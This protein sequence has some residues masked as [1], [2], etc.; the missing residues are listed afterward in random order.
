MIDSNGGFA[1]FIKNY[2]AG[3]KEKFE[4]GDR[5]TFYELYD[6]LEKDIK[7]EK[8]EKIIKGL[9]INWE[10]SKEPMHLLLRRQIL[11]IRKTTCY[12]RVVS[13]IISGTPSRQFTTT[14]VPIMEIS[15]CLH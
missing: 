12:T 2:E 5:R 8:K 10:L 4:P 13:L 9:N 14:K 6:R 15:T 7:K 11:Q 1:N 3:V